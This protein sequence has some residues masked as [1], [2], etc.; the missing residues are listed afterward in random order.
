MK[1][2]KIEDPEVFEILWQ[3]FN[4]Q[5]GDGYAGARLNQVV[6]ILDALDE[7]S[8]SIEPDVSALRA[9][10]ADPQID[11]LSAQEV[12]ASFSHLVSS[13]RVGRKLK[14]GGGDLNL[15]QEDMKLLSEKLEKVPWA[16]HAVRKAKK[17]IDFL[18][19]ATSTRAEIRR[20]AKKE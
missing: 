10:L 7:I 1:K 6:H 17:A 18:S 14:I 8:E 12:A 5:N 19:G 15:N 2:L 13:M 16:I 11:N 9:A 20:E 4:I 3:G